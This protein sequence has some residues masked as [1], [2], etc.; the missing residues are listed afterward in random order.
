M[1]GEPEL[2]KGQSSEWAQYLQQLLQQ[3]GAWSGDINGEFD[4]ALEQAVMQFQSAHG[5]NADGVVRQ[6]TWDALTGASG[7]SGAS[8]G[9]AD[10]DHADEV[11]VDTAN[12]TEFIAIV[13]A[14]SPEA[15]LQSIGIDPAIV[16]QDA[17]PNA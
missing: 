6:D 5:L 14:G 3:A 8:S 10:G 9:T 13:Q 11:Y 1:A 2:Q 7:G 12:L 17:Q 4:D 15:Y 16:T